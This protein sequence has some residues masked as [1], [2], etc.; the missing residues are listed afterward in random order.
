MKSEF[1]MRKLFFVVSFFSMLLLGYLVYFLLNPFSDNYAIA[2]IP[3]PLS[4]RTTELGRVVGYAD[5]TDTHAWLGIPMRSRLWAIGAG[6][7]RDPRSPGKE[8]VRAWTFAPPAC[9]TAVFFR[10]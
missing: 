5:L 4:I 3:D 9:S 6:E 8:P 10:A 1:V 2:K 7:R